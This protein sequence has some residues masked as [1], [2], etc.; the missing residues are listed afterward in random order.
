MQLELPSQICSHLFMFLTQLPCFDIL[1]AQP[2][3]RRRPPTA[4]TLVPSLFVCMGFVVNKVAL[5]LFVVRIS[6][7]PFSTIPPVHS[8]HLAIIGPI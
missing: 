2:V 7:F 8:I 1:I 5:S 4:D 6:V 3:I